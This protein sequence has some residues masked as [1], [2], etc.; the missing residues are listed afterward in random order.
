MKID[1]RDNF[2]LYKALNGLSTGIFG[3]NIV[4][5]QIQK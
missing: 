1:I 3:K 5:I 2:L 4:S